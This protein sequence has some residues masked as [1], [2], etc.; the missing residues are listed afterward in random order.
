MTRN[1]GHVRMDDDF[2]S[3]R[4][5]RA[6]SR[7]AP[8]ALGAIV[9]GVIGAAIALLYAPS[10]G[11]DL[12][13]GMSETIDDLA[14]GAKDIIQGAKTTAEKLFR[15]GFND[16]EEASESE[17]SRMERNRERADD[18]LDDADRTISEAR[19]R[20]SKRSKYDEDED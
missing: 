4:E 16:D 12:R 15:E 2:S 19:R 13:R 11:S 14:Q 8:F 7:L 9:G 5:V 18:I 10:E 1:N 20:S 6:P 17:P 3:R